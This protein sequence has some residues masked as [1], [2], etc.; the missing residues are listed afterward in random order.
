[1]ND[2][3]GSVDMENNG[4][5]LVSF[6]SNSF[7]NEGYCSAVV[8]NQNKKYHADPWNACMSLLPNSGNRGSLE[9]QS[10]CS[11]EECS[12]PVHYGV[13]DN[14]VLIALKWGTE[15]EEEYSGAFDTHMEIATSLRQKHNILYQYTTQLLSISA[16]SSTED[17]MLITLHYSDSTTPTS[18]AYPLRITLSLCMRKHIDLVH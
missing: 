10:S 13:L 12:L 18:Y 5:Q 17:N 16:K 8:G 7:Y 3:G 9:A 1:M 4:V 11:V 15:C 2:Q 6:T 14:W